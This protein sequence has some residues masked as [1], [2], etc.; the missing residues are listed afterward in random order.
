V[1][2]DPHKLDVYRRSL[3]LLETCDA[4]VHQLPPGRA[5]LRDQMD[6]AASSIVANNDALEQK[7]RTV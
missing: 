6:R 5:H 7:A 2:F 3:E 1:A 4:I